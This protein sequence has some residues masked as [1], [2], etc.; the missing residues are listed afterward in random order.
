[1]K[2]IFELFWLHFNCQFSKNNNRNYVPLNYLFSSDMCVGIIF[3]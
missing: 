2:V 1:M 3:Q